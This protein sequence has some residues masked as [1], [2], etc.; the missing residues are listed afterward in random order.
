MGCFG[1]KSEQFQGRLQA[2]EGQVAEALAPRSED[3]DILERVAQELPDVREYFA[4]RGDN[5]ELDRIRGLTN[6]IASHLVGVLGL[7]LERGDLLRVQTARRVAR[8]AGVA[9]VIEQVYQKHNTDLGSRALQQVATALHALTLP[10]ALVE[11]SEHILALLQGANVFVAEAPDLVPTLLQYSTAFAVKV[12]ELLQ[13]AAEPSA[14]PLLIAVARKLDVMCGTLASRIRAGYE[15]LEPKVEAVR[16]R[17][18]A[19]L[20]PVRLAALEEELAR[21][22]GLRHDLLLSLLADVASLWA[23]PQVE[24]GERLAAALSA[25]AARVTEAFDHSLAASEL[26]RQD[27]LAQFARRFDQVRGRL[28]EGVAGEG[29]ARALDRKK[30][31]LML[32]AMLAD[33]ERIIGEASDA[34]HASWAE[35]EAKVK[36]VPRENLDDPAEGPKWSFRLRRGAFKD[37]SAEKSAEVESQYQAWLAKGS[38]KD[39]EHRCEISIEVDRELPRGSMGK[40]P[41]LTDPNPPDPTEA[42]RPRCEYGD[43]CYRKNPAHRKETCHPGDW[44]WDARDARDG[45]APGLPLGSDGRPPAGSTASSMSLR[46]ER[47][48][49]DFVLMT[50]V[51]LSRDRG[52]AMR[53]IK[54]LEALTVAQKLTQDYFGQVMDFVKERESMFSQ[55]DMELHQLGAKERDTM[56][57]QVKVALQAMWP[58]L[59]EFLELAVSVQ[60]TKTIEEVTALLGV[61]AVHLGI[62]GSLKELRLRDVLAELHQAYSED[63]LASRL[64]SGARSWD[65]V[66]TMCRRQKAGPRSLLDC[67]LALVRTKREFATLSRRRVQMRCQALLTEYEGDADFARRFREEAASVLEAALRRAAELLQF[68]AAE[69]VLRAASSWQCRLPDVAGVMV[70]AALR[71]AL[72]CRQPLG[73]AV[74]V[75]DLGHGLARAAQLS[76]EEICDLEPL[77]PLCADKALAEV[78]QVLEA[79]TRLMPG[80]V[81]V[82]VELRA[83]LR[84]EELARRLDVTFWSRFEPWYAAMAEGDRTEEQAA[85]TEWAIAL[86]EQLKQPLPSWMMDKDQVEALRRLQAALEGGD[87]KH[88]REAVIFAKQADIKSDEKLSAMYDEAVKR[89]RRLKRLPSGWEVT[90]LVGDD[91]TTKMFKKANV[92]SAELKALFQRMFDDT[93]ASI[94]TRDRKGGVVPR[95]YRVERI[96][97][98]MNAESWGSYLKR[99]DGIVE[100]CKRFP[101]AAPCSD[102]VW[103]D[104]S[105]T[106]ATSTLG[107]DILACSRFPALMPAANEYLMFHGTKPEAA[108]SIACKHFDMAFACKTGLFGAGLYFAESCSKSDEYAQPD[109]LDRFPVIICRVALGRINYCPDKD[110]TTDPGRDKLEKSCVRGEYHSVLGDRVKARGTFREFVV[111]DHY[112]VYPH[113]IVW[114]TRL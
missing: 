80:S 61:R 81:K 10:E 21:P 52:G 47:Y 92:E 57:E 28:G 75:L 7:E 30:A 68:E 73:R 63:A 49:L 36:K 84:N 45:R 86:C 14:L 31:G 19:E 65:L 60:D 23:A 1:S 97:S 64:G 3:L 44:D 70:A 104:W 110:P 103:T 4:S 34:L 32:R 59:Q 113:Y 8:Q 69:G 91:A 55:V 20:L 114:Y 96:V 50:Q 71:S 62:T 83:K 39:E 37:F 46:H 2:L 12:L 56:E 38:P 13:A 78:R 74:E 67:R 88:L 93:K 43:R 41:S 90:D 79:G 18:A 105:G 82:V 6:R 58:P 48:S 106:V 112:Q 109:S 15:P 9:D 98:V 77:L 95:G 107:A 72:A 66:R 35:A 94:V 11:G 27:A 53:P 22:A 42:A 26:E 33:A 17:R 40:V 89:L 85:A 111:Y 25:I 101:G 87:E 99:L 76:L 16:A 24:A 100:Q 29:L 51:N 108:D 5:H 54:R 102:E